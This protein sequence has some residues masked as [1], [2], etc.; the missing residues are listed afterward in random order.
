LCR[1][2]NLGV[3]DNGGSGKSYTLEQH[4]RTTRAIDKFRAASKRDGAD[5]RQTLCQG[6]AQSTQ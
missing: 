2:C 5:E 6:H 1:L 3:K 4:P